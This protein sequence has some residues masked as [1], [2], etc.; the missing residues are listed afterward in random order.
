[1]IS[2]PLRTV[3]N[4]EKLLEI[5]NELY[6]MYEEK[7]NNLPYGINIISELRA[8]ENANSRILLCLLRY[9]KDNQYPLLQLFINKMQEKCCVPINIEIQKP[10]LKGQEN[11]IDILIKER[12]IGHFAGCDIC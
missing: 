2:I 9:S 4:A 8:N 11:L 12:L 6:A 1:M 5:A 3:N 10:D 7:T